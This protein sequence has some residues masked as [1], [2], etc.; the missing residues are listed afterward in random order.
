VW[1]I[2]RLQHSKKVKVTHQ[3]DLQNGYG[4]VYL[5]Y[6][7]KGKIPIEETGAMINDEITH[8]VNL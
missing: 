6:T 1:L 5:P 4:G 3:D 7:I 2:C 8:S